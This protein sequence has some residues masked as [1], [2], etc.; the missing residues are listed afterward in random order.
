M[1]I[2]TYGA[3]IVPHMA[4]VFGLFMMRQFLDSVP[5]SLIESA[6]LDSAARTVLQSV[7]LW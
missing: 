4:D 2:D 6:N 7:S 5:N 1:G 3:M